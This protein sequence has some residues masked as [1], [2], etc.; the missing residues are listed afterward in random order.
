MRETET[1]DAVWRKSSRCQ[2]NSCVEV[3]RTDGRI[4][5]RNSDEPTTAV[6][7]TPEEWVVFVGGLQDGEF[8]YLTSGTTDSSGRGRKGW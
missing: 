8:D 2:T 3:T 4:W 5:V 6:A 7:F 1:S